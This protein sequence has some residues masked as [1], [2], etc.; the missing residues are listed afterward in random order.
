MEKGLTKTRVISELT[1]SSHG[2]LKQYLTVGREIFKSDPEFASHL[3]A[4]NQKRGQIRDSKVALPIIALGSVSDPE[5]VD[6]ALAHLALLS[7]RDLLRALEFSR[8]AKTNGNGRSIR[9]LVEK[10]LRTRESVPKWWNATA[11]QHRKTLKA[12]YALGHVKPNGLADQVLFKGNM[13]SGSVFQALASLK[14]MTP[15]EAAGTIMTKR[16]PFL[17]AV[18]A[19]GDRIKDESVVLALIEA[20]SAPELVTNTKML[21][22]LGIRTNPALRAAFE[23]GLAK[24]ATSK[25]G[26]LKTTRAAEAVTDKKLKAKLQAAQEKQLDAISV[27]GNWLVLGDKSGSMASCVETARHVSAILAKAV[28]GKVHLVFFDVT[29]RYFDVTGKTYEDIKALTKRVTADGGTSIGCGVQ[30]AITNH[31]D[32]DGIAVISDGGENTAPIFSE[33]YKKLCEVTDKE[34][35]VYLY[36]I[37]EGS[38]FNHFVNDMNV[39]GLEMH[40]F[41]IPSN[42]DYYSLPNIVQTMRVN[43]YSLVDEIMATPLL[44]VADALKPREEAA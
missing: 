29:P 36:L 41:E 15:K 14:N 26:T 3:I 30:Y 32:V 9:R 13:P 20:M 7:P 1:R 31:L 2:D 44:T 8:T 6:N 28:K 23:A 16:I 33:R 5:Y 37:G 43:R 35:P 42:V 18:G 19:L 10:Y 12:L 40:T 27:D 4:W 21:E 38:K 24:V 22:K 17:I 11:L 25:K 34:P 39:N